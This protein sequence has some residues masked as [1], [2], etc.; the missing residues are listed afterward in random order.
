MVIIT[1]DTE[2]VFLFFST[3]LYTKLKVKV[4]M[5]NDIKILRETV[6]HNSGKKKIAWHV[7]RLCDRDLE[8]GGG[9]E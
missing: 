3:S 8:C 2:N 5:G 4:G 1:L 7:K 6:K 9:T